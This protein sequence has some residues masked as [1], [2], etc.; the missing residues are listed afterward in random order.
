[1]GDL[2]EEVRAAT[3]A[4]A[5]LATDDSTFLP[6]MSTALRATCDDVD[7]RLSSKELA[8]LVVGPTD[9]TS[10]RVLINVAMGEA[11]LAPNAREPM[12]VVRMRHGPEVTWRSELTGGGTDGFSGELAAKTRA[13][14][15]ALLEAERGTKRVEVEVHELRSRLEALRAQSAVPDVPAG[16]DLLARVR[17]FFAFLVAFVTTWWKG[18]RKQLPPGQKTEVLGVEVPPARL[19]RSERFDR[20]VAAERALLDAEPKLPKAHEEVARLRVE[21]ASHADHVRKVFRDDVVA[22]TDAGAR[23]DSI[24]EVTVDHPATILPPGLVLVDAPSLG[25]AD[26]A[27]RD[28]AWKRI[29]DDL[30]GCIVVSP[31]GLTNVLAPD[32]LAR[33]GPIA[34]HGVRG[35]VRGVGTSDEA[36]AELTGRLRGVLPPLFARIREESSMVVAALATRTVRDR[37]GLLTQACVTTAREVEGQIDAIEARRTALAKELRARTIAR[38]S[39]SIDEG[40]R[41]VLQRAQT[42]L[43]TRIAELVGEW[44]AAITACENRQAVDACIAEINERAPTRFR[45]LC[46]AL[47]EEIASDVQST[48][49]TLR[50]AA[51]HEIGLA[52]SL[53]SDDA[54]VVVSIATDL[55]EAPDVAP[56]VRG[57]PLR[58]T[59]EAFERKR[60]G[61]GLGGAAAGAA[62]GTLL[63]PGVGTAVGAMVGVLAGFVEGTGS[64]KRQALE[65]VR[66]HAN[67]V[68]REIAGRLDDAGPGVAREL[69]AS[70]D[71][72]L[73]RVLERRE[74][75]TA[76]FFDESDRAIAHEKKKLDDLARVR[77][78]LAGQEDRFA[79]LAKK[80]EAALAERTTAR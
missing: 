51:L 44:R 40:A 28:D 2:L 26:E 24:S 64:L 5:E 47:G 55:A 37:L 8:I 50:A 13:L 31:G 73:Q 17:A 9:P 6:R 15:D 41:D 76:R 66:A 68:E 63:F 53:E 10:K 43:R 29:R 7:R 52:R 61:I 56:S 12:A 27:A 49:D 42:T 62:V 34:P 46:D 11:L 33:L 45:A 38:V 32:L 25:H 71:E 23:G 14:A 3:S 74:G 30:G 21:I 60:L 54:L 4:L 39:M 16:P 36:V 18:R 67:E 22:L 57:E 69:T 19:P 75:P 79:A 59:H 35:L 65:H 1:M 80:A 58:T 77:T 70:I 20:I 78:A 72:S 48:S